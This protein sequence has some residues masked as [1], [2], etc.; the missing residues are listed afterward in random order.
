MSCTEQI[1]TQI[2]ARGFRLTPQR[3]A[4]LQVLHHAGGHLTPAEVYALACQSMPGLTETTVYRTLEFLSENGFAL[5][6][7]V[8]SGKL[9]YQVA[10][11][12]HHHVICRGCGHEVEVGH[13]Q[14]QQLYGQIEQATGFR[15]TTSHLTF[16]GLCPG[17]Q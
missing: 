7:H 17:C 2:R 10:G 1:S 12:D 4:I 6:A 3:L 11:H 13:D 8:G 5:A 14:L 16:F 15:L 9:I